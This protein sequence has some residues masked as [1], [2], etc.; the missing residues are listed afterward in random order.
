[1]KRFYL[2]LF[3][4]QLSGLVLAPCLIFLLPHTDELTS[5][6][7]ANLFGGIIFFW[8][9]KYIFSRKEKK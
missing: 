3:R 5:T 4:W 7:I 2:Y 8:V 9:D 6:I 1:M